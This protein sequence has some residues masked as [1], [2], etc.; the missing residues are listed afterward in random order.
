MTAAF[1]LSGTS[2][3]GTAPKNVKA[4]ACSRSQVADF[5][6]KTTFANRCRLWPST[7]TKTQALR[8]RP[9]VG[10]SSLPTYPKSTCATSPGGVM[11]GM[12]T[13]SAL[14]PSFWR[15]RRHSRFT[16]S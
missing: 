9:V 6:S 2:T 11:T 1:R 4:C 13:S 10:S 12:A 7:S 15:R 16:A 14:G 8:S 5:W 3:R